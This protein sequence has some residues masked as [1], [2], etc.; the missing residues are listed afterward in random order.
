MLGMLIVVGLLTTKHVVIGHVALP[1]INECCG[2][3]AAGS[4]RRLEISAGDGDRRVST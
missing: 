4:V 2:I 3:V 1:T